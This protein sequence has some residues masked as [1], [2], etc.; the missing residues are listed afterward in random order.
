MVVGYLFLQNL[1]F[2]NKQYLMKHFDRFEIEPEFQATAPA[3]GV[4]ICGCGIPPSRQAGIYQAFSTPQSTQPHGQ[5]VSISL[6]LFYW[7]FLSRCI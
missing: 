6:K 4:A 1:Y 5:N 7:H 3:R 2:L